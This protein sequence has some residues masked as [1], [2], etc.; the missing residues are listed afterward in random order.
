MAKCWELRGCDDAMQAE[1]PHQDPSDRCPAKCAFAQ[2]DRPT[3]AVSS[4]PMLIF[5]PSVDRSAALREVCTY[6]TFFITNGPRS[7]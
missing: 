2:C 3:H 1:C 7:S 6:C 4:D 5:D